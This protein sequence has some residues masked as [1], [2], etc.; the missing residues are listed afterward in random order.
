MA[1]EYNK[2]A[3]Y[4]PYSKHREMITQKELTDLYITVQDDTFP[5]QL[6]NHKSAGFKIKVPDAIFDHRTYVYYKH[7][8]PYDAG[9][10]TS[11][12]SAYNWTHNP[13]RLWEV[14]LNFAVHCTTSGIGVST[15]HLNAEQPLVRSLYRF[16][17]YYQIR[18]ILRRMVVPTPSD[19]GFDK[20]NNAYNL[21]EAR[22]IADEYGCSSNFHLYR[23]DF[24]F[25]RTGLRGNYSYAHN[26]WSRWIINHSNG[27]TKAGLEKISESIRAYTYLVL[28]SQAAARHGILGQNPKNFLARLARKPF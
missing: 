19:D 18:R 8:D 22:R 21:R 2:N 26:S 7:G 16:H 27:F 12:R 25:E 3:H 14:Q 9:G 28:T 15:E 17:V 10:F 5:A 6:R 13:M 11:A 20:Y 4:A 23:N 1:Y 24:Y